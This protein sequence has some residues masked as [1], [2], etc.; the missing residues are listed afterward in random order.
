[1]TEKAPYESHRGRVRE[2]VL[3]GAPAFPLPRQVCY[4]GM[5]SKEVAI[6]FTAQPE[7]AIPEE[8]RS[9]GMDRVIRVRVG[10]REGA[11]M[12]SK[13]QTFFKVQ[14]SLERIVRRLG[15]LGNILGLAPKATR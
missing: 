9:G 6:E 4:V 13:S 2:K 7:Q 1:M 11:R 12:A 10:Y 14:L 8:R 3:S 15:S 5:D